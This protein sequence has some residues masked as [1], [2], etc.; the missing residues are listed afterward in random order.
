LALMFVCAHRAIDPAVRAPLMLQTVLG[1]DAV[2]I[3]SAFLTAL[4]PWGS[5]WFAQRPGSSW[6]HPVPSAGA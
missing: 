1:L 4:P 5:D 2:T 6:P 3:G